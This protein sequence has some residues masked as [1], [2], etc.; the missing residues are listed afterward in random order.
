VRFERVVIEAGENTFTLDLHPRL[1]VVAGVGQMERDGLVNELV[2][3]L[4]AG[5]SGVH[6]ELVA[7]N[8]SRFAV[9]RPAGSR[10]RVV[11]VDHKVDVTTS[12]SDE[13]GSIDLLARAGLDFRSAREVMRFASNDLMTTNERDRMIQELAQ[14]NQNELW[15]AAE[16]LRQAERRLDEEAADAGS[17][18]EDAAVVERIEQRHAEF[19]AAQLHL[20]D[21]RR[22]RF[23]TSGVSGLL[24]IPAYLFVGLPVALPLMLIAL[25]AWAFSIVAWRKSEKARA[26]EEKALA[27]AGAASY[28]G[29]HLQRVNGLLSSDQSRKRLMAASEQQ[30][31]ALQRWQIIAGNVEMNWALAHRDEIT[32]AVK[33]RQDVVSM[34][35]VGSHAAQQEGDRATSLAHAVVNRLNQLRNLG[36]GGES[37]PMLLDDPFGSVEPTIKPSLLELLVRSSLHQQV[38]LFTEDETIVSWARLETMTGALSLVE[39][40]APTRKLERPDIT[41]IA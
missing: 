7:D 13:S 12:F 19:E 26:E 6:I 4:G 25:V 14:V 41:V 15:V 30:R 18:A 11:D 20:E 31:A 32:A 17:T 34:G 28:L 21:R 36:P 3:S 16:S 40:S 5:R 2:G 1:T 33:L 8:G 39:P 37:F 22:T 29:F 23:L 24:V 38:V 27:D 35:M 9:F 10:H